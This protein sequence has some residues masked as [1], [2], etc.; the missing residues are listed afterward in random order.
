MVICQVLTQIGVVTQ[1]QNKNICSTDV[2]FN[3]EI[4]AQKPQNVVESGMQTFGRFYHFKARNTYFSKYFYFEL[5]S[6][7]QFVSE[8]DISSS[9]HLLTQ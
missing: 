1:V 2:I 8:P 6:P 5:V 4:T 3:K 9:V 7:R